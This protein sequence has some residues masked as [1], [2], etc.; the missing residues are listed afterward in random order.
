MKTNINITSINAYHAL[1]ITDKQKQILAVMVPG[2]VY[3]RRQLA[4]MTGLETSCVAGRCNELL[5]RGGVIEAIGHIKC[6]I[7]LRQVEGITLAPQQM[8]IAA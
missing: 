5:E 2:K 3:S 4:T 7:T 1:D 8:E 6:P